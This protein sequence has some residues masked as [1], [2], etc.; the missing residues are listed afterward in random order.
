MN[1][2]IIRTKISPFYDMVQRMGLEE[3][4][5]ALI[6]RKELDW[7]IALINRN[8]CFLRL[9]MSNSQCF[10]LFDILVGSILCFII[11]SEITIAFQLAFCNEKQLK[12]VKI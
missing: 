7:L 5:L 9:C 3:R 10:G 11:H 8:G 1:E 12:R 6:D 2:F 4:F